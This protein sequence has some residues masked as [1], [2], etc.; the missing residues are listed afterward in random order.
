MGWL[1]QRDLATLRYRTT[2][3]TDLPE[4]GRRTW[5]IW[6]ATAVFA[7]IGYK[8][9]TVAAP[10]LLLPAIPLALAGPWLAAVDL[11]V[12]RLPNRILLHTA[13]ATIVIIGGVAVTTASATPAVDAVVGSLASGGAFAISHAV[14]RGGIGYGDVK[15]AALLGLA[16]GPLGLQPLWIGPLAGTTAAFLWGKVRRQAGPLAYGP[17]LLLG[18]GAALL[19]G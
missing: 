11:D 18:V 8:L 6:A 15:L 19:V 2:A 7:T 14:T 5:V 1:L 17:W 13:S 4:P 16:I 12:M 10:G 9:A 3:E